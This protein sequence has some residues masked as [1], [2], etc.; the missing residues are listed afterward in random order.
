MHWRNEMREFIYRTRAYFSDTETGGIVYHASY[1]D[2]AEHA[3]TEMLREMV[4]E[5]SQSELAE[6]EDGILILVRSISISYEKTGYLDDEIEVH[7]SIVDMRR[8]SCT[9][10]QTIM[11]SGTVLAELKVG[12]AFVSAATKRPA[13]IPDFIKAAYEE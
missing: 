2:W 10:K 4:P 9:V 5:K 1:I 13:L 6:G 11:R 7:T 3:R 12:L 8:L